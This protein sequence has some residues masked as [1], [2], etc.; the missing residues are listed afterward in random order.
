MLTE[1]YCIIDDFGK[2]LEENL[3]E[4]KLLG[5]TKTRNV[6]TVTLS[7]IATITLFYHY[8][9]YKNFKSYYE[10]HVKIYLKKEFPNAPSYSRMIELKQEIFCLVI[11][12]HRLINR[13]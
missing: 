12:Q 10:K 13:V 3:G 9:G 8:S 1:L 5:S 2:L 7:E 4:K 11:W 6:M